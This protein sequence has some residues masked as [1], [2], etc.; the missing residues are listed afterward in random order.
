[1]TL[2]NYLVNQQQLETEVNT[3][4]DDRTSVWV[5]TVCCEKGLARLQLAKMDLEESEAMKLED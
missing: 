4:H 3:A 5:W 1:M 2:C